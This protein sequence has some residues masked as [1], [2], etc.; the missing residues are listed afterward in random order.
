MRDDR[1]NRSLQFDLM[2]PDRLTAECVWSSSY[3]PPSARMEAI[4]CGGLC[5]FINF[6]EIFASKRLGHFPMKCVD[7]PGL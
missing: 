3:S 6:T 1:F 7:K 4:F 5:R 2:Q